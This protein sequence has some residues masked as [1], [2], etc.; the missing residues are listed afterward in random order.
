MSRPSDT[1]CTID[2]YLTASACFKAMTPHQQRAAQLYF[3]VKELAALGGTDYTSELGNGGTLVTASACVKNQ[4][5]EP[6]NRK[7][8]RMVIDYDNANDAG[9]A[10]STDI[11][12]IETAIACLRDFDPGTLD[13]MDLYITCLLGRHAAWPQVNR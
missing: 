9:A 10:I 7:L 8:A 6:N 11:E 4:L 5:S 12:T 13:A 1:A 3:K 2:H